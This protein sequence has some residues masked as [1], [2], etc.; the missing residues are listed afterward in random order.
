MAA[1]PRR[2]LL[3]AIFLAVVAA[4]VA[5]VLLLKV[6]CPVPSGDGDDRRPSESGPSPCAGDE[7]G[8]CLPI[9]ASVM[10][11]IDFSLGFLSCAACI[12]ISSYYCS[13]DDDNGVPSGAAKEAGYVAIR[14]DVEAG[15]GGKN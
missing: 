6:V 15:S 4:S 10:L 8:F 13:G 11:A 9:S 7:P 2:R 3:L 1:A 14:D 12:I 5:A